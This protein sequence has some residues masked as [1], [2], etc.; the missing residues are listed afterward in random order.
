MKTDKYSEF[1]S[2]TIVQ[3]RPIDQE[4]SQ[5]FL[6]AKAFKFHLLVSMSVALLFPFVLGSAA[7]GALCPAPLFPLL[8]LAENILKSS[9]AA[10]AGWLSFEDEAPPLEPAADGCSAGDLASFKIR[11]VS[12]LRV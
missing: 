11:T 7:A 4:R 6:T 5:S 9:L 3:K 2:N 12:A 1:N 8:F 10:F